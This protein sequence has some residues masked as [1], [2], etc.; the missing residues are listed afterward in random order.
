[1]G[2]VQADPADR[3]FMT[4][5]P[6]RGQA[7]ASIQR[8]R[9][10]GALP[11]PRP[12]SHLGPDPERRSRTWSGREP[13]FSARVR[14]TQ[15]MAADVSIFAALFAGLISFL[16]PCVLPLVPPYLAYL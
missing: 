1:M 15:D 14:H 10:F 2:L 12:P 8:D 3:A 5:G 13:L 7:V 4:A 6:R 9:R 11:S 16:S